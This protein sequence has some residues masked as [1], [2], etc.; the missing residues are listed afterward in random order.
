MP[1][2]TEDSALIPYL[3]DP[4]I[5]PDY[6]PLYH[7]IP[8]MLNP[9]IGYTVSSE[10]HKITITWLKYGDLNLFV[11]ADITVD[12]MHITLSP[13]SFYSD[14]ATI[15]HGMLGY[16]YGRMHSSCI[17]PEIKE[18]ENGVYA[19][20]GRSAVIS[21]TAMDQLD[22]LLADIKESGCADRAYLTLT[23]HINGLSS[24]IEKRNVKL[25]NTLLQNGF[26][27]IT[28]G[29][30]FM[31]GDYE[32]TLMQTLCTNHP[33]NKC[34]YQ[35]QQGFDMMTALSESA[36]AFAVYIR[37]AD[38][39]VCGGVVGQFV[40]HAFEPH[41]YINILFVDE[42]LRGMGYGAKIM[43]FAEEYI[44]N[45]GYNMILLGTSSAYEFHI[46]TGY[47][48]SRVFQDLLLGLDDK[49]ITSYTMY[50]RFL[51]PRK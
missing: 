39:K 18:T 42:S 44:K 7:G 11:S 51:P 22:D 50:K 34:D 28:G 49:P 41:A 21:D 8:L 25:F 43:N 37:D 23:N 17:T 35:M 19:I 29:R 47:G 45:S 12:A 5:S 48:A 4:V 6:V 3:P 9:A 26:E 16:D 1:H 40:P 10:E 36:G 14:I 15:L 33:A 2:A 31:T 30:N 27:R 20:H 13:N 32:S 46:N 24:V 38:N